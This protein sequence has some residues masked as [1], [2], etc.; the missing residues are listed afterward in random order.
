MGNWDNKEQ[1]A[2]RAKKHSEDNEKFYHNEINEAFK[3]KR[4]YSYESDFSEFDSGN[5]LFIFENIGSQDAVKKYAKHEKDKCC[6]LNF[7]SFKNP[8]GQFIAGSKAQ[9][10]NLCHNSILYNVL[11][12][13]TDYYD[14]NKTMLNKGLYKDRAL[15]LD[16]IVFTF[17]DGDVKCDVLTCAAPNKSLIRYGNFDESENFYALFQRMVFIRKICENEKVDTLILG[18]WGCGVFKQ[19]PQDVADIIQSVF[20]SSCIKTIVLAVPGNDKNAYVFKRSFS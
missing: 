2:N 5:P 11:M 15:Y 18:A 16:D 3:H 6:V 7:A 12:R 4:V 14:K 17:D 20:K 19:N 1:L 13:C 8:G 10:E 9:E